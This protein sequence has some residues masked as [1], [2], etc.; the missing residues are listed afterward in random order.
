MLCGILVLRPGIKPMLPPVGTQSL[1][2]W[3]TREV[4]RLFYF[5][6]IKT[7]QLELQSALITSPYSLT[8]LFRN[9]AEL[10]QASRCPDSQCSPPTQGARGFKDQVSVVE[11]PTASIFCLK[12]AG[13]PR[14]RQG[15]EGSP[16]W[17][18]AGCRQW[19]LLAA[20]QVQPLHS[21]EAESE[22]QGG[23]VICPTRSQ[24]QSP[25]LFGPGY[26]YIGFAFPE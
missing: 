23:E 1:N 3:T 10:K 18:L 21:A 13:C 20:R 7:L 17:A 22:M 19:E 14:D 9:T 26:L 6:K 25:F 15:L 8:F 11:N 16:S 5:K 4:P 2:H 24:G 12:V